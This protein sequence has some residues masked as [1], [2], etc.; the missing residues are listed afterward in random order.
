[1]LH[2]G[3][4][5]KDGAEFTKRREKGFVKI[6]LFS[7]SRIERGSC[8]ALGENQSVT[9]SVFGVCGIYVHFCKIE[10]C[11]DVRNSERAARMTGRSCVNALKSA[12]SDI[13]C[14]SFNISSFVVSTKYSPPY[15]IF[16]EHSSLRNSDINRLSS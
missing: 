15:F 7:E 13:E 8:M 1:M 10:I 3:V 14:F 12:E 16:A 11:K 9:I 2:I 5:L 4:T 6:T